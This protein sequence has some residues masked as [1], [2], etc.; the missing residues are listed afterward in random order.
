MVLELADIAVRPG[1]EDA[2]TDAYR[3]AVAQLR[4]SRGSAQRG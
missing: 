2:F 3:E 1:Q 4:A